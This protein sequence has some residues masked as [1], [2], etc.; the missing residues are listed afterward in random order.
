MDKRTL[1]ALV[2][3]AVVIIVTPKLFPRTPAPVTTTDSTTIVAPSPTSALPTVGAAP[4]PPTAAPLPLALPSAAETLVVSS[5][6]ARTSFVNFGA[7]PLA[8]AVSG[9]KEPA[10]GFARHDTRRRANRRVRCSDIVS[11]SARTRSRSTR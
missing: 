9:E 7:V 1:L 2:L 5:P 6:R 3:M 4:T 10:S 8:V 11:P